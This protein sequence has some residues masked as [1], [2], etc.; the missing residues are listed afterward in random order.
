MNATTN[1]GKRNS[2][3]QANEKKKF[4]KP[5]DFIGGQFE[6]AGGRMFSP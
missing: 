3:E 2:L 4:T 6:H 1:E 5:S